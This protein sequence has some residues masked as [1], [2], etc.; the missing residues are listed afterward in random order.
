[1]I[2]YKFTRKLVRVRLGNVILGQNRGDHAVDQKHAHGGLGVFVLLFQ[3]FQAHV[4]QHRGRTVFLGLDPGF[5]HLAWVDCV[6][7]FQQIRQRHASGRGRFDF[8][9][10]F[11]CVAMFGRR[12]PH[13]QA[14]GGGSSGC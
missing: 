11:E 5:K 1:M 7:Q 12:T 4:L 6:G 8:Q 13:P 9:Q 14:R 10:G 3:G 2:P